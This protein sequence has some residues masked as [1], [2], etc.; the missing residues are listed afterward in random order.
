MKVSVIIAA[1]NIEDYIER[2]ILSVIKQTLKE[3]EIIVVNDGSTD[4]TLERVKKLAQNNKNIRIINQKNKGLVEA[5]KSGL[6]IAKGEYILFIDGDD[7]LEIDALEKLY[8]NAKENESDIV[9]YNAFFAYEHNK[10]KL[11]IIK[12]NKNIINKP[13]EALFK[14][15]ILPAIWA[16]LIKRD[17]IYNNKIE[18]AKDISFAEDLAITSSLF[19]YNPKISIVNEYLYNYYQREDSITNSIDNRV[20]EIDK[21]IEFIKSQLIKKNI[22]DKYK[23]YFEYMIYIHLYEW[24]F[25]VYDKFDYIHKSLYQQYTN[26]NI[27][28]YNNKYIIERIETY[29]RGLR[30]RQNAYLKGYQIGKVYD[31][32]RKLVK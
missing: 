19:M 13:L 26:R 15:E 3:I 10:K 29:S 28:I 1:Y 2:C 18:F 27:D 5:R 25:L 24:K 30:I 32:L 12:C 7:W 20:L 4:N 8:I 23:L 17:Y 31:K 11:D 16:K 9:L 21:A 22:Y 14:C 6:K